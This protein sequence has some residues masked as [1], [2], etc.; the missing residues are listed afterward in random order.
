MV[1][2]SIVPC[3]SST[4]VHKAKDMISAFDRYPRLRVR[5]SPI[6]SLMLSKL[7]SSK[8]MVGLKDEGN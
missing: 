6:R 7:V 3:M 4:I 5:D 2:R 8:L 1:S